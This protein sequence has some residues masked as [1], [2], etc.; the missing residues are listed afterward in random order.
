M[1]LSRAQFLLGLTRRRR[2]PAR[3][4]CACRTRTTVSPTA[5]STESHP[6]RWQSLPIRR[7]LSHYVSAGDDRDEYDDDIVPPLVS[8]SQVQLNYPSSKRTS[9]PLNL[10]LSIGHASQGGHVI[11]GSNGVGKS[12]ISNALAAGF[13]QHREALR[14]PTA[15]NSSHASFF[16][17]GD[18]NGLHFINGN[19]TTLDERYL[20]LGLFYFPLLF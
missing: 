15:S 1:T 17:Q 8:L 4:C 5:T 11:L 13:K 10:D 2:L 19:I 20:R 9:Q 7:A 6:W 14:N 18:T 16:Q 12:L 3:F